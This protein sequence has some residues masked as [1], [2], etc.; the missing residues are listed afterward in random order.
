MPPGQPKRAKR[1]KRNRGKRTARPQNRKTGKNRKQKAKRGA[2]RK[3][4]PPSGKENQLERGG[5]KVLREHGVHRT[6]N[7]SSSIMGKRGFGGKNQTRERK[8]RKGDKKGVFWNI[9]STFFFG[10]RNLFFSFLFGK[11]ETARRGG[12]KL[13]KS[14]GRAGEK[15]LKRCVA[16]V[17]WKH[18]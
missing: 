11:Q 12:K 9:I 1:A 10:D 17:L 18:G 2:K 16:R 4:G 14:P 15:Q 8:A 6:P 3:K 13:Q 7:V 5:A